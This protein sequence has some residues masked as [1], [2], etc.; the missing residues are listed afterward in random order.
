MYGCTTADFRFEVRVHSISGWAD[1]G[2]HVLMTGFKGPGKSITPFKRDRSGNSR[3]SVATSVLLLVEAESVHLRC[4]TVSKASQRHCSH[5]T[6]MRE[7]ALIKAYSISKKGEA[8]FV[9]QP[10][11]VTYCEHV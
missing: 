3:A 11:V 10:T 5:Q 8:A 9:V 6:K 2:K 1:R 4:V 7:H